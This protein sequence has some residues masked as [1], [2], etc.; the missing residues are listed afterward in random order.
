MTDPSVNSPGR[1]IYHHHHH[2]HRQCHRDY[3]HSQVIA[4]VLIRSVIIIIS[5]IIIL[6][7]LII[8]TIIVLHSH[9]CL[10]VLML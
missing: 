2:H 10:D 9:H 4:I 8:S 5:I 6:V 1:S 7:I 3:V